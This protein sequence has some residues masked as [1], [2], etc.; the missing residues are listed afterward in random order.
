MI[1]HTLCI[2]PSGQ[3]Q[4][5]SSVFL[6]SDFDWLL[7]DG[8]DRVGQFSGSELFHGWR[9][10]S[11]MTWLTVS[12]VTWFPGVASS[13]EN[14]DDGRPPVWDCRAMYIYRGPDRTAVS[15]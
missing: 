7:S 11:M 9:E 4:M 14:G 15:V 12:L 3:I 2:G 1:P 8:V 13:E 5:S 10:P 6:D